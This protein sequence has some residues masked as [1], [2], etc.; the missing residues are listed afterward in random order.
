MPTLPLLD[1][2]EDLLAAGLPL[3]IDEYGRALRALAGGFGLANRAAL[4]RMCRA[5]WVKSAEDS[6][7]FR[8]Y[9]DRHFPMAAATPEGTEPD[10]ASGGP[11]PSTEGEAPPVT[12]P[13]SG[14]ATRTESLLLA[15]PSSLMDDQSVLQAAARR[16]LPEQRFLR[17]A[18]YYPVTRRQ[19]KQTWRYLRKPVREGPE[20][21]FSVEET[22]RAVTRCGMLLSPSLIPRRLNRAALL[23][24]IDRKGSMTPF[25]GLGQ[26]LE[27]TAVRG[28]R[29]GDAAVYYFHDYPQQYVYRNPV[30]TRP[31]R[32]EGLTGGNQSQRAVLIFSDAGAARGGFDPDRV[33]ATRNFL[34]RMRRS[35]GRI[36]WLNPM[37]YSRWAGTSAKPIAECVAMFEF[38]RQG[39]DHAM[40]LLRGRSR[41]LAGA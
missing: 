34:E 37:P 1:L 33:E 17:N 12:L 3:G 38:S 28:G 30:M 10:A 36:A 26:R 20:V 21:E 24:L 19:M 39:M 35:T 4:E 27:D 41:A 11:E 40:D 5:L 23:L 14:Q 25:H 18:E 22:V 8:F 9:F 15:K 29:L 7:V 32:V 13:A 6:A 31:L 16:D 2:F